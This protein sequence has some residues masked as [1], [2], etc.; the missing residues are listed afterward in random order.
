MFFFVVP[1]MAL[2]SF[3]VLIDISSFLYKDGQGR[4]PGGV[5]PFA[6]ARTSPASSP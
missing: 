5:E 4:R 2:G 1:K 6:A 3:E